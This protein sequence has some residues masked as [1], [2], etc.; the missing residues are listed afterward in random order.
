M[1]RAW[2][3][4]YGLLRDR[5]EAYD[6]V[7]QAFVV[8][9]R[10]P[11][12]IPED[13][14][15]PWFA[16]VVA[17][18]ARN[19]RRKKRPI[20]T[21]ALEP[22]AARSDEESGGRMAHRPAGSVHEGALDPATAAETAETHALLWEALGTLPVAEREAI[23]LTHMS[24]L[25]HASAAKSLGVPRATLSLRVRKGLERIRER[26]R[27]SGADPTLPL[28]QS[29]AL[30]P[31]AAPPG[32]WDAAAIAWKKSAFSALGNAVA[33]ST[34]TLQGSLWIM[35]QKGIVIAAGVAACFAVGFMTGDYFGTEDI[36][37]TR[38]DEAASAQTARPTYAGDDPIE[39]ARALPETA[40]EQLPLVTSL[41]TRLTQTETSLAESNEQVDDLAARLRTLEGEKNANGPVFT[42]GQGGQLSGVKE[43][44]WREL[45][46][47]S[48]VVQDAIVEMLAYQEDG[49][50]P[51]RDLL[52]RI[53]K[54]VERMRQYEYRTLDRLPTAGKHNG[55]LTHPIS[56]TNLLAALL[57][58]AG[59]PLGETQIARI[60]EL[61]MSFEETFERLRASYPAETPR[62]KKLLDEYLLK[63]DFTDQLNEVLTEEQRDIAVDPRIHRVAGLD[64]YCPTLLI[65]HTSP[66][67]VGADLAEARTKLSAVLTQKF[68]WTPEQQTRIEP[69]LDQ[70]VERVREI[71]EPTTAARV[72]HYTYTQGVIAGEA[73]VELYQNLLTHLD[74]DDEVRAKILDDYAFYVPRI[75]PP[76]DS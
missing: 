26:L 4:A 10:K 11:G 54:N 74:V 23:V 8:A 58:E 55:E 70:W 38:T 68:G 71:A 57:E 30:C 69:W 61:G 6:A 49:E 24:G 32:G 59:A 40:I 44:N 16:V 37:A 19:L 45:A 63:G 48:H 2:H 25:S 76:T 18:E 47:A 9:A 33:T 42:F 13:D 66:V 72:K 46:D 36:H 65:L 14:P 1:Q 17:H 27:R 20:P 31:L 52:I 7:Q 62:V 5:D 64:L 73:T 3:V 56:S 29:L 43:A 39:V 41:R 28:P 67:L 22:V 34:T 53:Q 50:Q 75:V 51:P 35:A 21:S 60:N 12:R 15:W